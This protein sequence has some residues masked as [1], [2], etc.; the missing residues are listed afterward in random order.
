M[1]I[2]YGMR[3]KK[4]GVAA[5]SVRMMKAL[6]V[7]MD[8]VERMKVERVALIGEGRWYPAYFVY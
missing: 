8:T 4:L 2:Y 5:A 6:I 1:T 7:K 3:A